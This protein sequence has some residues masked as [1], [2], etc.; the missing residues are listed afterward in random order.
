MA[1]RAQNI[2]GMDPPGKGGGVTPK[3]LNQNPLTAT[4]II[5]QESTIRLAVFP[6][7]LLLE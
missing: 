5:R 6:V 7:H 4:K 2:P 3:G 1:L